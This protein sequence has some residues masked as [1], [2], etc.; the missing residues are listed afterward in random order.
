MADT[1]VPLPSSRIH[2]APTATREENGRII[3]GWTEGGVFFEVEAD[4]VRA[5]ELLREGC[6]IDETRARL[7]TETGEDCN[8]PALVGALIEVGIV[9][10]ID[11]EVLTPPAHVR[12]MASIDQRATRR[13]AWLHSIPFAIAFQVMAI[14]TFASLLA[15]PDLLAP[16]TGAL[17]I[18][19]FAGGSML[20]FLLV[21]FTS[22]YLHEL[23]HW[24]MARSFGIPSRIA[25]SIR[26]VIP[27]MQTDVTRAWMLGKGA[28]LLIFL[29]GMMV[30]V[31][32]L[33]T[34]LVFLSI[35]GDVPGSA[36]YELAH[37]IV[38]INLFH[39][40]IQMFL[41]L[42]TDLY[43]VFVSLTGEWNLHGDVV[44]AISTAATKVARAVARRRVGDDPLIPGTHRRGPFLGYAVALVVGSAA[45][46]A[47]MGFSAVF[48]ID[49]M[50]PATR[51][52]I[53]AATGGWDPM[54]WGNVFLLVAYP[55]VFLVILAKFFVI[56]SVAG[57]MKWWRRTF[58]DAVTV[59]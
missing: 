51:S 49:T 2:L 36:T 7:T 46:V 6:T 50:G 42:R 14:V 56:D 52:A 21:S 29:G 54:A 23:G 40:I 11:G 59:G 33:F 4:T 1:P 43:F 39:I 16:P 5:I 18:L 35:R 45:A 17:D 26:F 53:A 34:V 37:V 25:M 15:Q 38:F 30:N 13:L 10:A 55:S 3:L 9:W 19:D 58:H 22:V 20:L 48:M 44:Q 8:I 47:Y 24:A 41:F 27:I 12:E 28:R 32:V 31:L 57:L